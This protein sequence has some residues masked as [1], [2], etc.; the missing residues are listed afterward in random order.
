MV[1]GVI[2]SIAAINGLF[3]IFR[4]FGIGRCIIFAKD[5]EL[6]ATSNMSFMINIIIGFIFS[7]TLFICA[8]I[9]SKK[10]NID[11]QYLNAV[12]LL[13]LN[14]L[15]NSAISN[16]DNN[17][18][19]RLLFREKALTES[20]ATTS[21]A[22][23]ATTLAFSGWGIWS[24]II[25]QQFA[26]VTLTVG[27]Y[28]NINKYWKPTINLVGLN[29][30]KMLHMGGHFTLSSVI[31]YLYNNLDNFIV[32]LLLGPQQ[33][34]Y[35]SRSYNYAMIPSGFMGS[36]IAKITGPLYNNMADA[37]DKLSNA[38]QTI[39]TLLGI[40]VP[41]LFMFAII[42]ARDMVLL[43]VGPKWLPMILPFQILLIFSGLRL[44]SSSA[45][46][47]FPALGKNHL[48]SLIPLVYLTTLLLFIYPSTKWFGITGTS[49]AV[50]A[51][52][53]IGGTISMITA[54]RLLNINLIVFVKP[55]IKAG[56]FCISAW[57]LFRYSLGSTETSIPWL[58]IKVIIYL[59]LYAG[60]ALLAMKNE[61]KIALTFKNTWV[62]YNGQTT[63]V[64]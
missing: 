51:T 41:P 44:I 52:A 6:D 39:F 36:V 60:F 14:P 13:A 29:F 30:R 16:F 40:I 20:I 45:S 7:A 17:L 28:I 56:L 22:I 34:G 21:C 8:N 26:A 2:A 47:V 48:I 10:L 37:R 25:A 64:L 59:L 15:I 49:I 18:Q 19:R 12:R 35:Y 4:D 42:F 9:I 58:S 23:V 50:L 27:Y 11:H 54:A 43:I 3:E 53:I 62:K 31:V 1:F 38:V 46:N 57:V 55:I 33:L 61:I 32:A 5:D 24:L 63:E